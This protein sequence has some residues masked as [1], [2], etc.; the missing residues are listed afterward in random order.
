VK[1]LFWFIVILIISASCVNEKPVHN[2][3]FSGSMPGL[4]G[5]KVYLDELEVQSRILLDS[6]VVEEDGSFVFQI[7]IGQT[8]FYVLY[9]NPEHNI[10]LLFEPGDQPVLKAQDADLSKVYTISDSPGSI[11]LEEYASFMDYQKTRIDSLGSVYQQ[12]K[13]SN[14]Y[15]EQ[16]EVLDSIYERV[17]E[18]QKVYVRN[19]IDK[20]TGSLA[21]LIVLNRKLGQ[22]NVL[23]EEKDFNYFSLTDS[24]L[25]AKYPNNKHTKDHHER[26]KQIRA[27]LFDDFMALRKL[28]A[29][30]KAPDIVLPDTT[31][32]LFSLKS[33]TGKKVI[34]CFWA[35]WDTPSRMDNRRLVKIYPDLQSKNIKILSVSLDEN[36]SVWQGAVNLDKLDWQQVSDLQGF[37]SEV[38]KNYHVI[39][40]LPLYYLLDEELHI[41]SRNHQLDSILI[42]LDEIIL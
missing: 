7:E 40:R 6:V 17:F 37:G 31:G 20:N 10:I 21:S 22:L 4:S 5:Q 2:L 33:Y 38:V 29:G 25:I 35:G 13:R 16:K 39:K 42:K 36:K 3:T 26:V 8:G 24:I 28:Q 32:D 9:T 23:D 11:L 14:N 41:I 30:K 27:R 12:A 18:D 1:S 19:F 15:L 34:V